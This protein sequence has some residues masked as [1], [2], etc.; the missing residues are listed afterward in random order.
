MQTQTQPG[1]QAQAQT[2]GPIEFVERRGHTRDLVQRLLAERQDLL[3]AFCEVAGLE[4]YHPD[5]PVRSLLRKFC[6]LLV[7]YVAVVHFELC[8]RIADGGERRAGVRAVAEE[9]FP[10]LSAITDEVVEFNDR[11]EVLTPEKLAGG[12]SE[13]LSRVGETL[14]VRF[15]LEDRLFAAL[16]AR[17]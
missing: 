11:Y 5:K 1:A 7:D 17:S 8:T 9:V 12:L 14:A 2:Q 15:E 6:Q 16:L 3:V 4:P 13:D 10:R